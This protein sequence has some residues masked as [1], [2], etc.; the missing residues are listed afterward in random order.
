MPPP[1]EA[2]PVEPVPPVGGGLPEP[3][4]DEGLPVG[5]V[6]LVALPLVAP[7]AAAPPAARDAIIAPVGIAM[8]AAPAKMP[9]TPRPPAI[10]S[11]AGFTIRKAA[12]NAITPKPINDNPAR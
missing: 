4:D 6:P 5:A 9:P 10:A 8:A 1:D 3:L 2:V 7:P 12:G 11:A